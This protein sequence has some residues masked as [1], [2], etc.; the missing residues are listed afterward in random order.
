[1]GLAVQVDLEVLEDLGDRAARMILVVAAVLIAVAAGGNTPRGVRDPRG[2]HFKSV[3][4]KSDPWLM[5]GENAG[6]YCAFW[7]TGP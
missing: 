6:Y 2:P 5:N 4:M 7:E 3:V 1:V